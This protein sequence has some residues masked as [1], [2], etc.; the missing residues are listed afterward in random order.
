MSYLTKRQK[1]VLDYIR[2]YSKER[3]YA[4]TLDEISVEM[5]L[6]SLATVHKH[7]TALVDKK[8]L[9]RSPNRARA[10]E[11][12][13]DVRRFWMQGNRVWDDL[14]KCWWVRQE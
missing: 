1:E 10:L 2:L 9:V 12:V 14:E 6:S 7:L 3:G 11:L 13:E 4:P 5:G 8:F